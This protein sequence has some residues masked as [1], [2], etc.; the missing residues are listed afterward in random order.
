[1]LAWRA[2]AAMTDNE[3]RLAAE[4]RSWQQLDALLTRVEADLRAASFRARRGTARE[5]DAAWSLAPTTR[6]AM[7]C[8]SSRAQDRVRS[9]SRAT[10]ASAS[11]TGWRDGRVEALYWP[12]IDN[13]VDR[14]ADE[15]CAERRRRPLSCLRA[16]GRQSL[17]RSMAVPGQ[18]ATFR[19]A[20]AS[21]SARRRQLV[22]RWLALQ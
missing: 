5:R 13:A 2:T 1:M 3:V 11:A 4:A 18:R 7:R 14:A 17:V 8:W 10:P 22:E 16:H 15:L 12:H 6:P 20:C 21:S 9:T 19:A